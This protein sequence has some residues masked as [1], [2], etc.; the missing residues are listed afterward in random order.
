M[1]TGKVENNLDFKRARYFA[2][3]HHV[4]ASNHNVL[5]LPLLRARAVVYVTPSRVQC[6]GQFDLESTEPV[7]RAPFTVRRS[8]SVPSFPRKQLFL[9]GSPEL[10]DSEDIAFCPQYAYR[11]EQPGVYYTLRVPPQ[12][13]IAR[14][15][16]ESHVVY[17]IWGDICLVAHGE[18]SSSSATHQD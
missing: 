1:E 13:P 16:L 14:R 6:M 3:G 8:C 17:A 2:G 4:R 18:Y 7:L 12:C 11:A 15:I 5:F 9:T 10:I